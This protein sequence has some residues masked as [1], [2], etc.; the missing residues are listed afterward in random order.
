VKTPN[1]SVGDGAAGEHADQMRAV[2]G[3]AVNVA[4]E[5]VGRHGQAFER[6]RRK[7]L[8]QRLLERR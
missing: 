2:F 3:A 8:L 4:V 7:P 5:A 6:F 1:Q